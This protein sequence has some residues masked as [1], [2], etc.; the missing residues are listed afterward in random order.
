[1]NFPNIQLRAP[2]DHSPLLEDFFPWEKTIIG[3]NLRT[4]VPCKENALRGHGPQS[5]SSV[6]YLRKFIITMDV[7]PKIVQHLK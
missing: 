2:C 1:M 7:R 3:N 4:Y 6:S 5:T